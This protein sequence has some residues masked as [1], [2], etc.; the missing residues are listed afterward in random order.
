VTIGSGVIIY[1]THAPVTF[2]SQLYFPKKLGTDPT[3]ARI[4]IDPLKFLID[5]PACKPEGLELIDETSSNKIVTKVFG[6]KSTFEFPLN[7]TRIDG[8][9]DYPPLLLKFKGTVEGGSSVTSD[10]YKFQIA[11]D[12]AYTGVASPSIF[13]VVTLTPP[14]NAVENVV[15]PLN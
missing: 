9:S 2:N 11:C 13:K 8:S 15:I 14:N 4:T 5:P 7:R 3:V 6:T 10:Q 1:D 12:I